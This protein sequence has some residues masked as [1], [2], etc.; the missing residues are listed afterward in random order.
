MNEKNKVLVEHYL[1]AVAAV[2]VVIYQS[3]NHDLKKVAW[4]AL[5]AVLAPVLKA[6]VDKMKS[7]AK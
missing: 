1:Y 2:G 7:A 4:A 6:I 3:G 5:V